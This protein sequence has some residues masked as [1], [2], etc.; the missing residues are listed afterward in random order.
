MRAP[1]P[2]SRPSRASAERSKVSEPAPGAVRLR[3]RAVRP[4]QEVRRPDAGLRDLRR[5]GAP[6]IE[7]T[8]LGAYLE[9]HPPTWEVEL[10]PGPDGEGTAWSC[11]HGLGRW[12]RDCGCNMRGPARAGTRSGAGRCARRSTSCATPRPTST[13]TPRRAARRSVGRAR[14]LRRGGRRADRRARRGAGRARA[15]ALRAR[16]RGGARSGAAAARA[17]AR[18]AAHVRQLRLVLRRHRRPRGLARHSHGGARARSDGAGRG[19]RR[20]RATCSRRSPRAGA[21]ASRTA[22]AP[23]SSAASRA[24]A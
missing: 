9:R 24:I 16:G 11:A 2:S 8:N 12:Q 17:A 4:P 19:A 22:R 18:D 21:I 10:A 14:R 1:S 15:A 6:G 3:R 7:V 5:G 13:R 23:T 20:R